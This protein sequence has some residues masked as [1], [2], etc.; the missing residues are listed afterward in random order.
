[1]LHHVISGMNPFIRTRNQKLDQKCAGLGNC[2][3]LLWTLSV[4]KLLTCLDFITYVSH[5]EASLISFFFCSP[6]LTS[7]NNIS[8]VRILLQEL[9]FVTEYR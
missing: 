2:C 6:A 3:D 1:M 4:F 9:S 7:A 8:S 5:W